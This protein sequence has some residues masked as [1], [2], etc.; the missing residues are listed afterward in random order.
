[1]SSEPEPGE[2]IQAL[3]RGLEVIE[4]FSADAPSMTLSEVAS[5]T[6]LSAATARRCLLTLERLGYVRQTGRQFR[7]SSRVLS[8]GSSYFA[9]L[10]LAGIAQPIVQDLADRLQHA[11]SVTVLEGNEVVYVTHAMSSGP[12]FRRHYVGARLPAHATSTGHVLLASLPETD[13]QAFL[14]LAPFARYT[15]NTPTT[16][17]AL[18]QILAGVLQQGY[19]VVRDTVEYG[20]AAVAVPIRAPRGTVIAALNSSASAVSERDHDMLLDR[21]DLLRHAAGAIEQA[22]VRYPATAAIA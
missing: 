18:Q 7:L 1:V 6:S 2:F 12:S 14:S 9:S 20:A 22:L 17:R 10:N 3:A 16:K 21:L 19:A 11:C 15:T 13:R 4:A 8:L 5:R